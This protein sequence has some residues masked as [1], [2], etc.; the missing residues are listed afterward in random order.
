VQF[1]RYLSNGWREMQRDMTEIKEL[2]AEMRHS[3][4]E[5]AARPTV[6]KPSP[7]LQK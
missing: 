7:P 1:V 4:G 2:A 5:A 6:L 3:H